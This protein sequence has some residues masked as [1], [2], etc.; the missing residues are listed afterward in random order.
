MTGSGRAM[1]WAWASWRLVERMSGRLW[2]RSLAPPLASRQHAKGT[3]LR[4]VPPTGAQGER[5]YDDPPADVPS[6]LSPD[7][8]DPVAPAPT[9]FT[10]S[11]LPLGDHAT[12]DRLCPFLR[13]V[14]E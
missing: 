11:Q 3:R 2:R 6:G 1:F 13:V 8:D 14:A 5:V 12:A 7:A 9:E 10:R 4:A